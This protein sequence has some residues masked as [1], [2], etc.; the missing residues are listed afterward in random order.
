M[1]K[2][3]KTFGDFA[4]Y[5]FAEFLHLMLNTGVRRMRAAVFSA[6]KTDQKP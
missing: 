5:L 6:H 3:V 2:T 4:H 1:H